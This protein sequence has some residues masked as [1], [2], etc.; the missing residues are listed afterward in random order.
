MNIWGHVSFLRKV[1]SRYMPTSGIAGS[2]VSS[3]FSFLSYLHTGFHSGCTNLH[4]LQQWRRVPFSQCRLQ[5]L[6]FVDLLIITILT[7]VRWYLIVV[8][9]C[10]SVIRSHVGHFFICLL[11]I[12]LSSLEKCLFGSFAHFWAEF[13]FFVFLFC[14][15]VV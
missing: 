6:L 13:F 10:I 11:V 14:C 5:H 2:Y 7:G 12:C 8:L 1:L 3:I 4:S 15:Q 9:I